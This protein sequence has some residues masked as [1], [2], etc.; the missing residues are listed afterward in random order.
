[1]KKQTYNMPIRRSY[2]AAKAMAVLAKDIRSELRTRYAVGAIVMFAVITVVAVGFSLGGIPLDLNLQGILFWLVIYFASVAG[3]GQSFIKEEESKTSLALRIYAPPLSVFGGKLLFNLLLLIALEAVLVPLFAMLVGL[4]I[5]SISLFSAVLV[6]G[7]IGLACS[8]TIVAAI[9]A[10]A[11]IKG[12]LFAV[13][14]FPLIL[15]VLIMA[16]KGTQ[17]ALSPGL[18]FGS[19]LGELQVLVS[20]A[21]IML[22]A[23]FMLFEFVWND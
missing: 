3:L 19:A 2:L 15:P 20:Y 17:K 13:L 7:T 4:D 8:T 10:K 23:G 1:M 12:V 18:G 9:I 22:I 6:V 11:S 5:R 14:S 16:I 21:A